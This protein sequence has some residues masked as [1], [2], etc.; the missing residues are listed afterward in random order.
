MQGHDD[1][2]QQLLRVQLGLQ[3]LQQALEQPPLP[4]PP[5][6]S[7]PPVSP[8]QQG[9]Q[10]RLATRRQLESFRR[11]FRRLTADGTFPSE[12]QN[13]LFLACQKVDL[14]WDEARRFVQPE[15]QAIYHRCA[16]QITVGRALTAEDFAELQRLQKRL[17]L[18][19]TGPLP[20]Q[21]TITQALRL[22]RRISPLLLVVLA[23]LVVGLVSAAVFVVFGLPLV[24]GV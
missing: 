17:G 6:Q 19:E 9:Q 1:L 2:H 16:S 24:N 7:A 23:V 8:P 5:V 13:R 11:A 21:T 10:R 4:A 15:A 18:P 12:R 14:D 20:A 22:R 3:Q